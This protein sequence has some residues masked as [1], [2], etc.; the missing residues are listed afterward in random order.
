MSTTPTRRYVVYGKDGLVAE[1]MILAPTQAAAVAFVARSMLD[2]RVASPDDIERLVSM[3]VR[4]EKP[5]EAAAD[6]G[7]PPS[8]QQGPRDGT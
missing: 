4:T 5:G 7:D 2:A 6:Q 3:G 8:N 1:R